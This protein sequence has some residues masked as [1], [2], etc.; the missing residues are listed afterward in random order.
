M[1][2]KRHKAAT[3]K[4][5]S[6]SR[7]PGIRVLTDTDPRAIGYRRSGPLLGKNARM[8]RMLH[9]LTAFAVAASLSQPAFAA[10]PSLVTTQPDPPPDVAPYFIADTDS[11]WS[12]PEW[13]ADDIAALR[14]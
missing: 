5:L 3:D 11:R 1:R 13:S 9:G 7:H 10:S 4:A 14:Q 2:L 8:K 12:S 6:F